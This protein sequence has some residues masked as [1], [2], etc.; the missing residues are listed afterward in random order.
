MSE[1]DLSASWKL[2]DF[3]PGG[4]EKLGVFSVD[5]DDKEWVAA[6]VPGDVHQALVRAG[7][8]EAPFFGEN[9]EAC[10]YGK[11]CSQLLLFY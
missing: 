7:R 8:I 11:Q 2:A 6:Q 10:R 4:G 3:D 9:I 1:T 5:Y